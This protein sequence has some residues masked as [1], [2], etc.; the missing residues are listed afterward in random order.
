MGRVATG[1]VSPVSSQ[2]E[3]SSAFNSVLPQG[4]GSFSVKPEKP[5]EKLSIR[6]AAKLAGL[7]RETIYRLYRAG[8]LK[9]GRTSPRKTYILASSLT[10]HL[11]LSQ[12][13]QIWNDPA[14]RK[15]FSDCLS[16]RDKKP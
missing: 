6:R 10:R 4:D 9:G 1:R 11:K 14:A 13:G 7:S 3:P 12:Q 2:C 8:F 15:K 5:E 16:G